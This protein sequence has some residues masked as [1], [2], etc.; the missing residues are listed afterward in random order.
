MASMIIIGF[1]MAVPFFFLFMLCWKYKLLR[2]KEAKR[3]FSTLLLKVD[4][5]YRSTII[6]PFFFFVRRFATAVVLAFPLENK[7]V[8]FQ[9]AAVT[10]TSN[11]WALY[12]TNL[13]PYKSTLFNAY[14]ATN[15]T[16]YSMISLYA[17]I[18]TD[19]QIEIF[20]KLFGGIAIVTSIFVLIFANFLM[21]VTIVFY[22]KERLKK[23]LKEDMFRESER[24]ILLQEEKEYASKS[25]A[26]REAQRF[27]G[28]KQK[29]LKHQ[30]LFMLDHQN[31]N[32]EQDFELI[33]G[34]E[35]EKGN[36]VFG[37]DTIKSK[38]KK[39]K[40]RKVKD[41]D[42]DDVANQSADI[43]LDQKKKKRKFRKNKLNSYDGDSIEDVQLGV[44]LSSFSKV[45]KDKDEPGS[46]KRKSKKDKKKAQ[47]KEKDQD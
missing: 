6:V 15:E 27:G 25:I 35:F 30:L 5:R 38:K 28:I 29:N 12:V 40:G 23:K 44:S 32:D 31:E 7:F 18:F 39:K 11:V 17:L 46:K 33:G 34:D 14:I 47:D 21:V 22:G 42:M 43:D 9:Y 45:L 36:D 8:F 16:F 4:K 20:I 2:L 3:S 41:Q 19:S 26:E 24:L 37:K 1:S 13:R 10:F